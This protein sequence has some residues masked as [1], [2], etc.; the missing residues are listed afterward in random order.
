MTNSVANGS[1]SDNRSKGW[2]WLSKSQVWAANTSWPLMF[3]LSRANRIVAS[4]LEE[5]I[6]LSTPQ[7]RI[8]FEALDPGGVSQAALYKRYNVD[9]ASITRTVQVMER[10]G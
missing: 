3:R 10:D 7:M 1:Q 5:N 6:N 8:L 9:P 4:Q 2:E